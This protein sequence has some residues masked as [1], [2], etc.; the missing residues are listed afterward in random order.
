LFNNN[1]SRI[2]TLD[3][4]NQKQPKVKKEKK[5]TEGVKTSFLWEVTTLWRDD[6]FPK[7]PVFGARYYD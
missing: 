3:L 7:I 2:L 1:L 4:I 6:P 5:I